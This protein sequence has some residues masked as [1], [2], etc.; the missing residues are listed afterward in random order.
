MSNLDELKAILDRIAADQHNKADINT[1]RDALI[2]S[3]DQTVLQLGNGN[4]NLG[5]IGKAEAV[6]IGNRVIYQGT[7]AETILKVFRQLRDENLII[8]K[9]IIGLILIVAVIVCFIILCINPPTEES[10]LKIFILIISLTMGISVSLL[11]DTLALE[12]EISLNKWAI[13]L[14]S[15]LT[16]FLIVSLSSWFFI[17]SVV[18]PGIRRGP[19]YL[20]Y[21]TGINHYPVLALIEEGIPKELTE[22]ALKNLNGKP[23]V[24]TDNPIYKN[25]KRFANE[26]G[27]QK[28]I[29]IEEGYS[30]HYQ[31]N[32]GGRTYEGDTKHF[33]NGETVH[34]QRQDNFNINN[35]N[36][37][38]KGEIEDF[39]YFPFLLPFQSDLES[40]EWTSFLKTPSQAD[41]NIGQILQY[42]KLSDILKIGKKDY[43]SF[44]RNSNIK[45]LWIKNIIE[46]NPENRGFIGYRYSFINDLSNKMFFESKA[47]P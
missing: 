35:K 30:H 24:D 3:G 19:I 17:P 16:T 36:Y 44:I 26:S 32:Q 8:R 15:G 43:S 23:L 11:L 41:N 21:I 39:Q 40:A 31:R 5:D 14:T 42:P 38:N 9:R 7:D 20:N 34:I 37:T 13:R 1:L 4:V 47:L 28:I 12:R 18:V 6:N 27:N 33:N 25:I 46:E 10:I 22:S 45:D 2:F 29:H